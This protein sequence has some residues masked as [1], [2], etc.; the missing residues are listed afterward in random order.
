MSTNDVHT[1]SK[2]LSSTLDDNVNVF[3]DEIY[4]EGD[5]TPII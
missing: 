5:K 1:T 2:L 3:L 4:A